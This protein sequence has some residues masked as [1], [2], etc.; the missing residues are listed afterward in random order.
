MMLEL[1]VERTF[2][3]K[4]LTPRTDMHWT[5]RQIGDAQLC[6]LREARSGFQAG[7]VT[8]EITADQ[9]TVTVRATERVLDPQQVTIH[10]VEAVRGGAEEMLSAFGRAITSEALRLAQ[11]DEG[12]QYRSVYLNCGLRDNFWLTDDHIFQHQSCRAEACV[13]TFPVSRPVAAVGRHPER[14]HHLVHRALID[15]NARAGR[16]TPDPLELETAMAA[17]G[18]CRIKGPD[19]LVL[20]SVRA[21]LGTPEGLRISRRVIDTWPPGSALYWGG[22]SLALAVIAIVL[23]I[24]PVAIGALV[25]AVAAALAT[26]VGTL[27]FA[28]RQGASIARTLLGLGPALLIIGFA[29]FYGFFARGNA[30]SIVVGQQPHMVD[31]FLLSF[32]IASTGGFLDVGLHGL[33]VRVAALLEML[34]M[35][36]VAGSSLAVAARTLWTRFSETVRRRDQE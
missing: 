3:V 19:K 32:G 26:L 35:V 29:I 5:P 14:L 12:S 8:G 11:S 16:T 1:R 36:T 21:L 25:A 30:P 4:L 6:V 9:L 15:R 10:L 31:V 28:R 17:K 23:S 24:A 34:L 27:S 7:A 13:V 33:A 22:G 18:S 2:S 20:E